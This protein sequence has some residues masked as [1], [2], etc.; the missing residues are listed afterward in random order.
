MAFVVLIHFSFDTFV[1]KRGQ[2]FAFRGRSKTAVPDR[3]RVGLGGSEVGS[4][5]GVRRRRGVVLARTDAGLGG[6]R[7]LGVF[8]GSKVV[9][10]VLGVVSILL[11]GLLAEVDTCVAS[12][13]DGG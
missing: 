11:T 2:G 13:G 9:L 4:G 10:G 5:R 3:D 12:V 6:A 7:E 8:G 1:F